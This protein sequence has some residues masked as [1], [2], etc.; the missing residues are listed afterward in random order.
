M[1]GIIEA[2]RQTE[3]RPVTPLD[4]IAAAL[5]KGVDPDHLTK[6]MD[7][8]E[9]YERNRAAE[10][11][12]EALA[13]FQSQCPT[14]RKN[15]K[16]SIQA[17]GASW[18]YK[19]ASYDDVMKKVGPILADCGLAISFRTDPAEGAGSLKL[20]CRVRH[21]IHFE[22]HPLTVPVPAMRVNDTQRF[23]AALKYAQRYALCAAL[24]IVVTDEDDDADQLTEFVNAEQ[25]RQLN[26]LILDTRADLKRFLK[27][28]DIT[29]LEQMH[30][31]DFPKALDMLKKKKGP[32]Q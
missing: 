17:Q 12:G 29:G 11:F 15:K 14:I 19:F 7:L 13:R 23:G 27:W 31:R 16:A 24:N 10:A 1:T 32:S 25:V 9:R 26:E 20:V 18:G 2:P 5:E 3:L 21:G 28:A 8:Q 22:D 4:L 6:L 30:A